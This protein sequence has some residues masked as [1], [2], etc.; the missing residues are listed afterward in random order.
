MSLSPRRLARSRGPVMPECG[1][2][3]SLGPVFKTARI[4]NNSDFV[5]I[6]AWKSEPGRGQPGSQITLVA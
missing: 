1:V 2:E 5:F 3:K 6:V 4:L